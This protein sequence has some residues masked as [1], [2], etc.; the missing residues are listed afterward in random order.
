[1]CIAFPL[2]DGKEWFD[3]LYEKKQDLLKVVLIP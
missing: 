2:K 3:T 1:M